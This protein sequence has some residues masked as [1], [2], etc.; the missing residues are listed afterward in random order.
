[1]AE[2]EGSIQHVQHKYDD[3]TIQYRNLQKSNKEDFVSMIVTFENT[4][5]ERN[6]QIQSLQNTIEGYNGKLHTLASEHE[7]KVCEYED[8]LEG[9]AR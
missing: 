7:S 1:M 9:L 5:K 8:R 4:L 6:K 3:L 2:Q